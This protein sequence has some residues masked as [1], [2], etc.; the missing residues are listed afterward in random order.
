[1]AAFKEEASKTNEHINML[2]EC[3]HGEI[4]LRQVAG[5]LA[6]RAVCRVRPGDHLAQGERYGII[7][8]SSRVDIFLPL[9]TDVKVQ[10]GDNVKAGE[11]VLAVRNQSSVVS[12]R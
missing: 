6:R 4:M 3:E 11:T 7:K 9:H 1:M 5:L 8:F 2:F 12:S 10:L